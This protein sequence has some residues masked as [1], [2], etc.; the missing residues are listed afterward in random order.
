MPRPTATIRRK[1]DE[2][3]E[4]RCPAYFRAPPAARCRDGGGFTLIE[5]LLVLLLVALLASLAA[6]VVTGSIQRARESTLKE[7]LY[8]MRK[9]IDDY[10]V[11]V[12]AYPAELED[13]A[14][15]RYL[16]RIPIDPITEK[17]DSWVL[18][19]AEADEAGG[20]ESGG[21]IDVHSGAEAQASDGT[22]YKDW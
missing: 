15:K 22:Y 4:R 16:R 9:A 17:R 19:Q 2:S 6:P 14:D 5:L 20:G 12:G 7:N 18:T 1:N 8:A 21:I 10:Y 11:D 13:L 3:G